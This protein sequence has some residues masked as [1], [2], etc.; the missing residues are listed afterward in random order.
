MDKKITIP[1]K[2]S[3]TNDTKVNNTNFHPVKLRVMSSGKNYNFSDFI[4]ESL[5][6][7]KDTISYAPILANIVTREDGEL[8]C[9]GHDID[10]EMKIDYN[11]NLSVKETYVEKPV[12]VFIENSVE[13]KHDDANDVDYLE[14]YGY[15]WKNYSDMYDILKRDEVKDVSV[16]IEVLDGGYRDSDGYY[17][18]REF[19]ILGVTCLGN[20]TLPAIEGSKIEFSVDKC[21]KDYMDNLEELKVL[22]QNFSKCEGGDDMEDNKEFEK[23]EEEVKDN[24]EEFAEDDKKDDNKDEEVCPKCGKPLD[25]CTCEDE[26][27]N[28]E[29]EMEKKKKKCSCEDH[30]EEKLYTQADLDKAI[31]DTKCEFSEALVEL[32]NLREFKA[33]YDKQVELQKLNNSMDEILVNFNVDEKIVKELR[34]KVINNEYSL[35]KFELELFRHNQTT[36]KEFS[37][38][39]KNPLPI[40]DTDKGMS[41]ADKLFALYGI[42]KRK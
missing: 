11:G 37:K 13:V 34:E 28:E 21:N 29:E 14:A 41:E 31:E 17:E 18:I 36:K 26:K 2:F 8:D 10:Y 42:P 4:K 19:N 38:E 6:K 9:N 5:N 3:L 1:S 15:I 23:E 27:D 25:E 30:T 7:A 12:G 22:L 32:A 20:N 24:E 16:E 39:D 40:V 35:D 33:E